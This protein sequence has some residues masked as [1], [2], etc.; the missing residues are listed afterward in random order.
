M[1]LGTSDL[2]LHDVGDNG[3][4]YE[5][6]IRNLSPIFG[7]GFDKV[8]VG[9]PFH[10]KTDSYLWGFL[11][12]TAGRPNSMSDGQPGSG[13]GDPEIDLF[14]QHESAY[15]LSTDPKIG[16][17]LLLGSYIGDWY[18]LEDV[19]DQAINLRDDFMRAALATP[20]YGLAAVWMTPNPGTPPGSGTHWQF[21]PAGVGEV[22]GTGL[23]QTINNGRPN[24]ADQWACLSILGDPTLRSSVIGP[25]T[26]NLSQSWKSGNTVNL[27]WS[28]H[29]EET[30]CVDYIY[31]APYRSDPYSKVAG[32]I[33]ETSHQFQADP[34]STSFMV[35]AGK[36]LTTGSATYENLSQ[37][38]FWP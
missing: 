14:L 13:T 17:Y 6:A 9:D 25:V 5:N 33:S 7:S 1:A 24:S 36:N 34:S 20:T 21:H 18:T 30:G 28:P 38:A 29:P 8:V 10:Q 15:F 31:E 35:R 32:P 2:N 26:I 23:T 37:G 27:S 3:I 4:A 12:G 22:I 16:F 19:Q 11:A